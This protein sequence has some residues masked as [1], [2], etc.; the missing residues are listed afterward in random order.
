MSQERERDFDFKE[1]LKDMQD[2]KLLN[3]DELKVL[4]KTLSGELARRASFRKGLDAGEQLQFDT[5]I[6]MIRK[7][8]GLEDA[9]ALEM[10]R[11]HVPETPPL[12]G[13]PRK[14]P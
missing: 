5:L 14:L 11:S 13:R 10:V 3:D 6:D 7:R 12:R 4:E 1:L 8:T 2:F 9:D